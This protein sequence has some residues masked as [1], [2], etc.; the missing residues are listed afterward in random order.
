MTWMQYKLQRPRWSP[1]W[2]NTLV[3]TNNFHPRC[4]GNNEVD[5][6]RGDLYVDTSLS[7]RERRGTQNEESLQHPHNQIVTLQPLFT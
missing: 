2:G 1:T 3:V 4:V 6:K 5:G 7:I